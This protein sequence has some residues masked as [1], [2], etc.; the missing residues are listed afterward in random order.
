MKSLIA[1][2]CGLTGLLG[3]A[4]LIAAVM[5]GNTG[6]A[7]VSGIGALVMHW[8]ALDAMRDLLVP[9]VH[10]THVM[11]PETEPM[12]V[13]GREIARAVRESDRRA[14]W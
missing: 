13:D 3:L 2:F 14:G 11:E 8:L 5:Q 6:A 4:G 7:V 9:V 12:T 10:I 1:A